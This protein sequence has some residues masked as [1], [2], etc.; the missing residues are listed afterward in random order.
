M[1]GER[2]RER[3]PTSQL[4]SAAYVVCLSEASEERL[5]SGETVLSN[6]QLSESEGKIIIEVLAAQFDLQK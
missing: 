4:H 6:T 3:I 2:E 5:F 1:F